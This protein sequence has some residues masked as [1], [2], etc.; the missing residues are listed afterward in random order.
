MLLL[1]ASTCMATCWSP[2][3]GA[4]VRNEIYF[5]VGAWTRE[6]SEIKSAAKISTYTV[7]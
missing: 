1:E 6:D 4:G 7:L 2:V 3:F 5:A